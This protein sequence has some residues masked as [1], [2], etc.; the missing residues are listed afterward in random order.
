MRLISHLK[1]NQAQQDPC[2]WGA[3]GNSYVHSLTVKTRVE[4]PCEGRI[5]N[6]IC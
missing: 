2:R 6:W 5:G 1:E 3:F 4:Q